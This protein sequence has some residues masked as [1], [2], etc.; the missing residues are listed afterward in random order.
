MVHGKE[1]KRMKNVKELF[2]REF[3]LDVCARFAGGESIAEIADSSGN[4]IEEIEEL[5]KAYHSEMAEA[6]HR[7]GAVRQKAKAASMGREAD[8][9]ERIAAALERLVE[10]FEHREQKGE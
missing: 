6:F 2:T 3:A 5:L 9:L 8:A 10:I 7:A 4:S 1:E